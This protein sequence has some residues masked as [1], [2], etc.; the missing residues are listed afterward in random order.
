[1]PTNKFPSN[2]TLAMPKENSMKNE[3]DAGKFMLS[4]A[5]LFLFFS[6]LFSLGTQ[7]ILGIFGFYGYV[8]MQ[9]PALLYLE[10]FRVPIG[11]SYLCT[12]LLELSIVWAAVISSFGVGMRKRAMG[13]AA[14][15]LTLVAFNFLRIIASILVIYYFGLDAGN[16]SHDL[17][18]RLFLFLTIAL[19][20]YMWLKWATS[21]NGM[22]AKKAR[23]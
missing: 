9:E 6:F 14:G 3:M 22:H 12:G 18:F 5:A 2:Y 19:F 1:M 17:L 20:Y 21:K 23:H 7:L 4:I 15:T 8:V 11:I 13:V 16:F 10:A